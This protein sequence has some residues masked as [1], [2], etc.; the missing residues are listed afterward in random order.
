MFKS[1]FV[2][3]IGRSNVGKS[4]LLNL[5]IGEK[6]TIMSNKPQTTRKKV[7]LIYTDDKMQ[8]IF[9]DTP[10]IQNPKNKLGEYMLNTSKSSLK[11]ADLIIYMV[12]TSDLIGELDDKIISDLRDI[13]KPIIL[14]INKIDK[15]SSEKVEE[16]KKMYE[17]VEIFTDIVPIS[18]ID[19]K[20]VENL[21]KVIEDNL[22]QG[23][24]Y[25]DEDSL[26]D[27]SVRDIVGELIR[28][29]TLNNLSDELP[30]GIEVSVEK[31]KERQDKDLIDIDANIIVEKP[32]HKGMVIGKNGKMIK[33]IGSDARME[34]EKFLESRVNLKLWVKQ[35]S[36]W[37]N[38]PGRLKY[39]GYE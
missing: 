9:L 19:G 12:D 37:R 29:S 22:P 36:E 34:I 21:L 2:S 7:Q 25:Y 33:K 1:G 27:Q 14:V 4:T 16:V 11:E 8:I 18:A 23:P 6:L 15:I 5:I 32:S 35:D 28:E 31:F 3:V 20:N 13:K 39:F 38:N 17:Q 30:H 26:T 10:G 24:M